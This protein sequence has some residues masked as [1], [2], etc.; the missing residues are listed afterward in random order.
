MQSSAGY[1][2]AWSNVKQ[3]YTDYYRQ[4]S[5]TFIL[6]YSEMRCAAPDGSSA[7]DPATG[8]LIPGAAIEC[9]AM[10]GD[11]GRHCSGVGFGLNDQLAM[12]SD[13]FPLTSYQFRM[14]YDDTCNPAS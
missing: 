2:T 9:M 8:N 1:Q 6:V 5:C 12:V 7:T 13:D 14:G 3:P 4:V 10:A 11:N